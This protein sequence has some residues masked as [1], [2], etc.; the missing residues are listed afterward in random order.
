MNQRSS[1]ESCV[2]V[3][4]GEKGD[5]DLSSHYEDRGII[6]CYL[7]RF[8]SKQLNKGIKACWKQLIVKFYATM[9][10]L[11]RDNEQDA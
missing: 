11:W 6:C 8:M 3:A 9:I 1:D 2:N 10:K 4:N 5:E 7:E